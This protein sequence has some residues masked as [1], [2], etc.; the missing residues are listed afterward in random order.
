MPLILRKLKVRL[1]AL[2]KWLLL[3]LPVRELGRA[4]FMR[5]FWR[6]RYLLAK[7]D[8]DAPA[9]ALVTP[10]YN[11]RSLVKDAIRSARAQSWPNI[12]H[13]IVDDGSTDGSAEV[14]DRF[15][16][17][18]NRSIKSQKPSRAVATSVI[19][20]K[21]AGPGAA[22]NVGVA[23]A[24]LPTD[25]GKACK[26]LLFLDSDDL[27][28]IDGVRR[29][30]ERAEQTG[31][32]L[33]IGRLE[34]I[35]GVRRFQRRDNMHVYATDRNGITID[36]APEVLSDANISAKLFRV[37]FWQKQ[38]LEFEV[39]VVFED[40]PVVV[41]A[42]LNAP[43][44]DIVSRAVNLWR[45]RPEGQSIT[46]RRT[47]LKSLADRL[48]AI[49]RNIKMLK[50]AA[51]AGRCNP[52]VLASYLTRVISLDLQLFVVSIGETSQDYF[53]Q[54]QVRAGGILAE[55]SDEVW[56]LAGGAHKD[57]VRL[58][59]KASRPELIAAIKAKGI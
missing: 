28:P 25:S 7:L 18:Y 12:K 23:Q 2:L 40:M 34:R 52:S 56:R 22:R 47:Q 5:P 46:Q 19:H 9:V 33:V 58:A 44:F 11:N 27:L 55:A 32:P 13:F 45:V 51:S 21:N 54:F 41:S 50:D 53:D 4:L 59:L 30:V 20:Q 36:D 49:E 42:Y 24:L 48:T 8:Q 1:R 35:D 38:K 57:L 10:V 26:Y 43:Q 15:A 31:S 16:A 3:V 29:L 17:D 14:L 37:D 6:L 39:G